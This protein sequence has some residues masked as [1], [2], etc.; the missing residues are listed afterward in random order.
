[1]MQGFW[2]SENFILFCKY[3]VECILFKQSDFLV[4]IA[5]A[6]L[7]NLRDARRW[8]YEDLLLKSLVFRTIYKWS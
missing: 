3:L 7:L 4:K 2:H 6:R 5:I 8:I 1:M